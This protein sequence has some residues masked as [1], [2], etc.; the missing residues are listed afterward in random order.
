[1]PNIKDVDN[2]EST[3]VIGNNH[4]KFYNEVL[5]ISNITRTWVFRYQNIEKKKFEEEK[6]IY[7]K[8]KAQYEHDETQNKNKYLAG[9]IIGAVVSLF[10]TFTA[11]SSRSIVTGI[12]FLCLTGF[13]SYIAYR[14]YNKEILYPGMPPT[15]REFPDKFGLGI[16]MNSGYKITFTA[17]GKEGVKALKKLQHDIEAADENDKSNNI[18]YFN[19]NENNVTVEN[20]DGIINTGDYANNVIN[21]KEHNL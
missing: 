18:I 14:I 20:N 13:L 17:I 11:F 8:N 12:F 15:E 4:I 1:M 5:K 21:V 3:V 10:I 7:E 9:F 16:E 19:L 6:R 2:I